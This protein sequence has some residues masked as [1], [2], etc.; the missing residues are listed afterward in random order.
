[1]R[2]W[3]GTAKRSRCAV[4]TRRLPSRRRGGPRLRVKVSF[5]EIGNGSAEE[6]EA[7]LDTGAFSTLVPRRFLEGYNPKP[8]GGV[9]RATRS[10]LIRCGDVARRVYPIAFDRDVADEILLG[11]DFMGD[12]AEMLK[13]LLKYARENVPIAEAEKWTTRL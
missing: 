4:W 2:P 1:M 9:L 5:P 3:R 8:E 6:L 12:N 11:R 13:R 7:T 10:M